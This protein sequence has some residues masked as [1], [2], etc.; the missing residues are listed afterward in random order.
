MPLVNFLTF[1]ISF[2]LA[3]SLGD[4]A[5]W[6]YLCA[7]T[8]AA[9][10]FVS[11]CSDSSAA[12]LCCDRLPL[13]TSLHQTSK[14]IT[15]PEFL[16]QIGVPH[17]SEPSVWPWRGPAEHPSSMLFSLLLL[18]GDGHWA[19]KGEA[20]QEG[21]LAS[22]DAFTVCRRGKSGLFIQESPAS[23][24][25]VWSDAWWLCAERT[26]IGV[27]CCSQCFAAAVSWEMPWTL[28]CGKMIEVLQG[29]INSKWVF[30]IPCN[31]FDSAELRS[32][33]RYEGE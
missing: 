21:R 2:P 7:C 18:L 9:P 11:R 20:L 32:L 31:W 4:G 28:S 10:W 30:H 12:Y 15:Q 8:D 1:P 16:F 25:G 17:P 29:C 22:R 14:L 33:I 5:V 6:F 27:F 24:S 23:G 13:F 19:A 26:V 3:T